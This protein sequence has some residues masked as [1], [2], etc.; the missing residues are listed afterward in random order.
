MQRGGNTKCVLTLLPPN[1]GLS[2]HIVTLASYG[3]SSPPPPQGLKAFLLSSPYDCPPWAPEVLMALVPAAGGGRQPAAVRSEAAQALSE[4]KRTHE[5]VR[6]AV[7][8]HTTCCSHNVRTQAESSPPNPDP[9]AAIHRL[10]VFEPIHCCTRS[11]SLPSTQCQSPP[12]ALTLMSTL[13]F[14]PEQDSL[15]ALKAAMPR[16]DWDDLQAVTSAAS[17][18][19]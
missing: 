14:I 5:Q 19:A 10:V 9:V 3:R 2:T 8:S 12:P 16:D 17:Y 4:F 7:R 6:L 13:V 15:E 11:P 18:F 1:S